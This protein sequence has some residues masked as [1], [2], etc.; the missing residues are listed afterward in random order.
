MW[1]SSCDL[2]IG[3]VAIRIA[4]VLYNNVQVEC[5]FVVKTTLVVDR[6]LPDIE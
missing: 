6:K 4:S 2:M 1:I 5:M 3:Y